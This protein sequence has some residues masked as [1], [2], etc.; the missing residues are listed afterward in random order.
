MRSVPGFVIGVGIIVSEVVSSNIIDVP[1][2]IVVDSVTRDLTRIDVDAVDQIGMIQVDSRVDDRDRH[3]STGM[4]GCPRF[5]GSNRIEI[6]FACAAEVIN[7]G[8]WRNHRRSNSGRR[9]SWR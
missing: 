1:V 7:V 3:A 6:P 9:R 5:R 8:K 4:S 2:L